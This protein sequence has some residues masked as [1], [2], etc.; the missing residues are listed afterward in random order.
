MTE[1]YSSKACAVNCAVLP[2]I[3]RAVEQHIFLL[4]IAAAAFWGD[5][6]RNVDFI[7]VD[8]QSVLFNHK[9]NELFVVLHRELH[10][11]PVGYNVIVRP[12]GSVAVDVADGLLAAGVKGDQTEILLVSLVV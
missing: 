9:V 5:V 12:F 10:I 6:E 4:V 7:L 3:N 11:S 1:Q 8:I 2:K